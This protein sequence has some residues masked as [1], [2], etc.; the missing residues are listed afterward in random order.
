MYTNNN[1]K[2]NR[3][4]QIVQTK[5]GATA[6]VFVI[7]IVMLHQIDAFQ[8]LSQYSFGLISNGLSDIKLLASNTISANAILATNSS[9]TTRPDLIV[10]SEPRGIAANPNTD[11]IYVANNVNGTVSVIDGKTNKVVGNMTVGSSP[12]GVAVN[13]VTDRVYVANS[14]SNGISI[15]DGKTNKVV[16]N[17]T[18]GGISPKGVAVNPET[19]MVYVANSGSYT[20]SVINDSSSNGGKNNSFNAASYI[21]NYYCRKI[22][23][24]NSCESRNQHGVRCKSRP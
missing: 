1:S 5:I 24:G 4:D 18:G 19:N 3:I 10:G 22:P 6:L 2:K 8:Y 16:D 14:G 9:Q 15:I 20:V 11:M 7:S 13:P 12:E 23:R 17:I 21:Q